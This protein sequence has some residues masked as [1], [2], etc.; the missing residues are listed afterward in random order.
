MCVCAGR[1]NY[2]QKKAHISTCANTNW[3]CWGRGVLANQLWYVVCFFVGCCAC[4]SFSKPSTAR[5][6]P[7]R[8]PTHARTHSHTHIPCVRVFLPYSTLTLPLCL[9]LFL[10]G[11]R[12]EK[13]Q[14]VQFV[15][16]IFVE[17]YDP[18]IEDSY[19]KQVCHFTARARGRC[20]ALSCFRPALRRDLW[21]LSTLALAA[22]TA[23]LRG[24][25]KQLMLQD[26]FLVHI[27]GGGWTAVHA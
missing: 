26:V 23:V 2:R 9:Y 8:S 4:F 12:A 3:S 17:K 10:S 21:L 14:T 27:G 18:T 11:A 19:R 13:T 5:V 16:G 6:N 22:T 15:Q 7:T 25:C 1:T 20:I 24:G